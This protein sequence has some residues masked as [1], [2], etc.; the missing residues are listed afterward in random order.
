MLRRRLGVRLLRPPRRRPRRPAHADVPRDH[1]AGQLGRRRVRR[2]GRGPDVPHAERPAGAELR[3]G[4]PARRRGGFAEGG[5]GWRLAAA[6]RGQAARE[7]EHARRVQLGQAPDAP[8]RAGV[9]PGTVAALPPGP[10]GR[11]VVALLLLCGQ[12]H[13]PRQQELLPRP[14]HLPRPAR[15]PRRLPGP[16]L[17][18]ER[19]PPRVPLRRLR[20]RRHPRAVR[21]RQ[22]PEL[23][24]GRTRRREE[25]RPSRVRGADGPAVPAAG[26]PRGAVPARV[27]AGRSR[28]A[29]RP[30]AVAVRGGF[31]DR[32][33]QGGTA[34]SKE[35][36]GGQVAVPREADLLRLRGAPGEHI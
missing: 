29:P 24:R 16:Q 21:A 22:H 20:R 30:R 27:A 1:P 6:A 28:E 5:G 7:Q 31:R 34:G 19:A 15:R 2:E 8:R 36:S 25:G 9:Q 11:I 10:A 12:V 14:P 32:T 23:D 18:H 26:R 33:P 4:G 13:L 17:R 35:E 3:R